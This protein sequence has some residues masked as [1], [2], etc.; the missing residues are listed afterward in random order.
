MNKALY[1]KYR[2]KK[3]SEIVGQEHITNTLNNAIKNGK[4]S[5]AYLFTGPRGVG[6]TSIARILAH[7]INSL[8]YSD[9]SIHLDII[10]IDA[11]SNRRIDEIR[12]LRDKVHIAPSSATYKVYIIDEVHMLTRE[13]F[14]ALLKT[15]EEPPKHV[16][17]IL[18][19]TEIHKLPE[20]IISR[21]QKFTFK[22]ID[23][24][25]AVK[26]LESIAKSEGIK[27]DSEA[28]ELLA[29]HGNGSFRDSISLLDQ[30]GSSGDKISKQDVEKIIGIAP[31]Q[32][33]EKLLHEITNGNPSDI[34]KSLDDIVADGT[35]PT[36]VAKQLSAS[37]RP[38]VISGDIGIEGLNL[39]KDLLAVSSSPEPFASLEI[40]IFRANL[41]IKPQAENNITISTRPTKPDPVEKPRPKAK[42]QDTKINTAS[43]KNEVKANSDNAETKAQTEPV[44]R[45]VNDGPKL[46]ISA[47]SLE[48]WEEVLKY[49]KK[50][51]N[52]LHGILRMAEV[53][54]NNEVLELGFKFAFH[55]NKVTDP[56]TQAKIHEAIESV[57][58]QSLAIEPKLETE[59]D[60]S[61]IEQVSEVDNN[62]PAKET[63]PNQNLSSITNVFG[64][65][66]VL[67]V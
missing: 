25:Q 62:E 18:A 26:H 39:L 3:L 28:L 53:N 4:I 5:H 48:W 29:I 40:A 42:G 8:P 14:N 67:E 22:S 13:A 24:P 47:D 58:G 17:F 36:Q 21:T 32:H 33:I 54:L 12:D 65:G 11:A 61:K 59:I 23:P 45:K 44:K 20:T 49:I 7:E 57:T 46:K 9:E 2:S 50:T 35:G 27:I 10:E 38:L 52:T 6:K 63:V 19:T 66:E 34:T 1:R 64:G 30:V 60:K 15:L 51:N 41:A 16:V 31:T 56:V 55:K 37:L 43:I